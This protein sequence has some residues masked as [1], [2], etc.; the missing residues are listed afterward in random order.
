MVIVVLNGLIIFLLSKYAFIKY[1]LF[2]N[3]DLLPYFNNQSPPYEGMT[4]GFSISVI[5]VY[6]FLF[7]AASFVTFKKRDIA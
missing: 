3:I 2:T 7:L 4:L 1:V 6:M 5:A